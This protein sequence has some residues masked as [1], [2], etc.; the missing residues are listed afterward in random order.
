M[1]YT[2][3]LVFLDTFAVIFTLMMLR[4]LY[5]RWLYYLHVFQQ[6]GYKTNELIG[7][8]KDHW[9]EKVIPRSL[10]YFLISTMLLIFG[11]EFLEIRL[12]LSAEAIILFSWGLAYLSSTK[13]FR[14][15]KVK[16]PLVWT[17][18]VKRLSLP[19]GLSSLLLP[20]LAMYLGF[21]GWL[22]SAITHPRLQEAASIQ[23]D[24]P[25][26]ALGLALGYIFIPLFLLLSGYLTA[27]IEEQIQNGYK[28]Q[29]RKKL[30]SLT[31]LKVIAITGSYG[32]TSVKFMLRDILK[33]RFSV[34]ITPGSFNT[35]MGICKVINNDLQAHHQI[36][37]LEMGA[38]YAGNIGELCDIAQPDISIVSNV[39]FAHL[40]TFGSQ[41]VIAKEK[42]TLV[43]RLKKGG[44]AV[45]NG[46]DPI[47]SKMGEDRSDIYRIQVGLSSLNETN[48]ELHLN[49]SEVDYSTQGTRFILHKNSG[50]TPIEP[51]D[52]QCPLLGKHNVQNLLL[53]L[54]VGDHLGLRM[55]TMQL[56]ASQIKP[57]QHRL[58]LKEVGDYFMIDDAFNSNPV[59]AKNAVEILGAFR[60][61]QRFIITPGIVELGDI[62]AEEN[63]KFG[64][65]IAEAKLDYA[66]I[67]GLKRGKVIEQG[68]LEAGG[69]PKRLER[70]KSLFE[71][72]DKLKHRIRSGD[73]VL[74]END[75][76][77]IYNE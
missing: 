56:A 45:L 38:R 65:H 39:G 26:L 75:L 62:E 6:L 51:L 61:S 77:D 36:L 4:V 11:T 48:S 72:N 70:V 23:F 57:V 60:S 21:G 10:V 63:Y 35:P 41:K 66:F 1:L 8:L 28:R 68:Y 49:A 44:V 30:A 52:I 58:E 76:P 20:F 55:N 22:N 2:Y 34:C 17:T 50:D 64:T 31:H 69:N 59:G 5:Y 24:A 40:E 74:Y 14:P 18:R 73:V 32:K 47:V 29:A 19:F 15:K 16:K 71:A 42:G 9:D 37:V 53:A 33:E 46:N 67:V 13:T 54:G 27:P 25:S 3:Y 7:W 43:Q 12:N